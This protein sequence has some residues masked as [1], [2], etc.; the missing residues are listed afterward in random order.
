MNQSLRFLA[1][2]ALGSA[3]ILLS[4]CGNMKSTSRSGTSFSFDPPA[5]KPS[6]ISAVKI[7]IS[8]SAGKLY[9]TEGNEV[10]L[11]TPVGVGTSAAPTPKG[12][13]RI[14]S[15]SRQPP[16]STGASSDDL[17]AI[18]LQPAYR[19]RLGICGKPYSIHPRLHGDSACPSIQRR[20]VLRHDSN[21]HSGEVSTTEL[22]RDSR[23]SR[24]TFPRPTTAAFPIRPTSYL[25]SS[26]SSPTKNP[27][28]IRCVNRIQLRVR[29]RI[30]A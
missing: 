3:A 7:H 24:R 25:T 2:I 22:L 19:M 23:R 8:T 10:L 12:N 9:V 15:K 17:L 4:S 11:A 18:F 16:A 6:S 13:F 27:P 28:A 20:K 26:Q 29:S 14:E 5:K 1:S 21:Q 30:K